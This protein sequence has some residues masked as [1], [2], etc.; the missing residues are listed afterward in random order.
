MSELDEMREEVA[1][2]LW[3]LNHMEKDV[4]WEAEDKDIK[5]GYRIAAR[6]LLGFC[7]KTCRI[8]VVRKEGELLDNP[9]ADGKGYDNSIAVG[10]YDQAQEDML[11]A[12][13]VQEVK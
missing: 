8:A 1:A 11:N 4:A 9:F 3:A 12:G 13:Y 7:T 6:A 2:W 10:V 5:R